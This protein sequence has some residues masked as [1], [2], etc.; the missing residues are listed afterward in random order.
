MLRNGPLKVEVK[1]RV[2][3]PRRQKMENTAAVVQPESVEKQEKNT[4]ETTRKVLHVAKKLQKMSSENNEADT[5]F[6]DVVIDP[7]SFTHTIENIFYYSFLVKDG[8]TSL[9]STGE[10]QH[11]V[12]NTANPPMSGKDN[13][14]ENKQCVIKLTL[15]MWKEMAKQVGK[16]PSTVIQNSSQNGKRTADQISTDDQEDE[17]SQKSNG[18]P[19]RRRRLLK[20]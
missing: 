19:S 15:D 4:D 6:L 2:V 17:S 11:V 1:T 13:L 5:D 10:D 14:I 12:A 9:K 3:K 20:K 18:R 16:T 8:R 7:Q